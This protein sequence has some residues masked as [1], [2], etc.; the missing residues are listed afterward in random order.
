MKPIH[1]D[2][3]KRGK[4][5]P[6][7]HPQD[8]TINYKSISHSLSYLLT[9]LQSFTKKS[10]FQSILNCLNNISIILPHTSPNETIPL[11]PNAVNQH[12]NSNQEHILPKLGFFTSLNR[13]QKIS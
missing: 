8:R 10:E 3:Q 12:T 11:L 4:N 7:I 1:R 2:L 9:F 5:T 6:T 13:P